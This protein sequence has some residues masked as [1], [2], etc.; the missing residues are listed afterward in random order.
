[1][2]LEC[3]PLLPLRNLQIFPAVPSPWLTIRRERSR[4]AVLNAQS[5]DGV[6]AVASFINSEFSAE[7]IATSDLYPNVVFAKIIQFES[8]EDGTVSLRLQPVAV[9][10][11][12]RVSPRTD[13]DEA[14]VEYLSSSQVEVK[15]ENGAVAIYPVLGECEAILRAYDREFD[16]ISE[17]AG[18]K[19]ETV[20]SSLCRSSDPALAVYGL[21]YFSRLSPEIKNYL[22]IKDCEEVIYITI[23]HMLYELEQKGVVLK[24]PPAVSD[25]LEYDRAVGRACELRKRAFMALG[26]LENYTLR[27]RINPAF[28]GKVPWPALR[29]EYVIVQRGAR[30]MLLTDG[31]SDAF[32]EQPLPNI[33]LGLE[34]FVEFEPEA[35]REEL[36]GH[37]ARHL[38]EQAAEILVDSPE[39]CNQLIAGGLLS[40]E[41][42][43]PVSAEFTNPELNSAAL[44]IGVPPDNINT[45]ILL[46]G[47]TV[48]L[49]SIKLLRPAEL[50]L[51][52]EK[53]DEGRSTL[54]QLFAKTKS[55]HLSSLA[56]AS[57]V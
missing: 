40:A 21:A 8:N 15:A 44:L 16:V 10:V 4:A 52:K 26:T 31:L 18:W 43:A 12:Q 34:L 39:A 23:K 48:K 55:D 17:D 24:L 36:S 2:S 35:K 11:L 27:Y 51:I 19:K 32:E 49:V 25:R 7:N 47:G 45:S 33:G 13:F 29:R 14:L 5:G 53:G 41:V 57:V 3:Y 6:V 28:M 46:P 54:A 20:L 38:I 30:T 37:W 56:R 22:V 1:M 50:N 9:G 42:P